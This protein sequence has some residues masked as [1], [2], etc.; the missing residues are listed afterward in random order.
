MQK[1]IINTILLLALATNSFAQDDVELPQRQFFIRGGLDLSRFMLPFINDV[2]VSGWEASLDAEIDHDFFPTLEFGM[3]NINHTTDEFDYKANGTYY[4]L[5]MN[6]NMLNYQHRLDRNIFYI[7][8]RYAFSIYNQQASNVALEN[9]WGEY[10]TSFP[11][12]N[13][14]HHWIEA[15]MGMRGEIFK[16]LYLGYT[17]RVKI[18]LSGSDFNNLTPYFIPGYGKDNSINAGMS[19]SIFYAIPIIRIK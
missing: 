5:G 11:K 10:E 15:V 9:E 3:N 7:G 1:Y 14:N 6:Y 2:E 16:N 19:Y 8:A 4:R 17:I 18:K 13:L 12:E